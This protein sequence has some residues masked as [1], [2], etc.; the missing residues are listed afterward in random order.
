MLDEVVEA[1]DVLRD[2]SRGDHFMIEVTRRNPSYRGGDR[3][4]RW[5]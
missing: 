5:Q 2:H 1:I 4:N 3:W